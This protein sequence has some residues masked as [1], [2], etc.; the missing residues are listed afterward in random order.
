MLNLNTVEHKVEFLIETPKEKD[1]I[2]TVQD[3]IFQVCA[4][5]CVGSGRKLTVPCKGGWR[6]GI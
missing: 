5:P 2:I 3:T 6:P 4:G 1:T